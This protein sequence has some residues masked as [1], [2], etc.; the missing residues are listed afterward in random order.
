MRRIASVRSALL[1]GMHQRLDNAGNLSRKKGGDRIADLRVL[2]CPVS[3]EE[4]VVRKCLQAGGLT[5]GQAPA[6]GRVMMN[7]VMPVLGY[8]GNNR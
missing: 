7:E 2:F 6:L 5:D 1:Q 4:V 3:R 8:M